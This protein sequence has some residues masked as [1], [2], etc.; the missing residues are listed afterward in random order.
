MITDPVRLPRQQKPGWW[1]S[2]ASPLLAVGAGVVNGECLQPEDAASPSSSTC[3]PVGLS[4][5]QGQG[6][7]EHAAEFLLPL[8]EPYTCPRG[9]GDEILVGWDLEE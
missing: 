4:G 3:T 7:R 5:Y 6:S 1:Q 9:H 8:G 2:D